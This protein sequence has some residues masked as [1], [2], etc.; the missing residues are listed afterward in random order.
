MTKGAQSQPVFR[1]PDG[2][3]GL[4]ESSG[5]GLFIEGFAFYQLANCGKG[6]WAR[7]SHRRGSTRR[8]FY[9]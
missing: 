3:S 4:G 2:G 7:Q 8:A 9:E 6:Y 5:P 1:R